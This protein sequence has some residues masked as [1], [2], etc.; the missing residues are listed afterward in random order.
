MIKRQTAVHQTQYK[1]QKTEQDEPYQRS[2]WSK[3]MAPVV[4]LMYLGNLI[5]AQKVS[6]NLVQ[7]MAFI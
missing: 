4:L 7:L 5:L 1:K 2:G 6:F 3:H